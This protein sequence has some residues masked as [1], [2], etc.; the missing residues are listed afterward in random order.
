M[1]E[2]ANDDEVRKIANAIK[3]MMGD[4]SRGT[5]SDSNHG[6]GS[7]TEKVRLF[8]TEEQKIEAGDL[9]KWK[10]GLKNKKF[11]PE[12]KHVCVIDVLSSPVIK[13]DRD[14]GS[15]YFREPLD[16]ILA[17]EDND[18]DLMFY[19]YDKRRFEVVKK[20]AFPA[21]KKAEAKKAEE[22]K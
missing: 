6:G 3:K 22:A 14:S 20:N 9:V 11:P 16:L 10:M 13:D 18:G 21:A 12:N 19:H 17:V 4:D 15:P 2:I 1:S 7:Y 8:L 5:P